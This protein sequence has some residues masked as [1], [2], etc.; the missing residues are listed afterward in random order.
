M[1]NIPLDEGTGSA[2]VRA[3]GTLSDGDALL[4][5]NFTGGDYFNDGDRCAGPYLHHR[6]SGDANNSVII[7]RSTADK[8]WSGQNPLGRTLRPRFGGQDTLAFTVVGV[9][10]DV[11]QDDWRSPARRSCTSARVRADRVGDDAPPTS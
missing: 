7:S 4:D 2:R 5:L 8:L 6:R 10:A 1:N 9:V 11:K 3:D